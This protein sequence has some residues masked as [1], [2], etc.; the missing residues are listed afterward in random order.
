M[1]VCVDV[2][3][4]IYETEKGFKIGGGGYVHLLVSS[5]LRYALPTCSGDI[6]SGQVSIRGRKVEML[7]WQKYLMGH[8]VGV[9]DPV[10][11]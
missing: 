7:K 5:P 2:C 1:Y 9:A 4:Y 11:L 10:Y 6:R 3:V 8:I